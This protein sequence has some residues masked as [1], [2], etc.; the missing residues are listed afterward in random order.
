MPG[1]NSFGNGGYAEISQDKIKAAVTP[2]YGGGGSDFYSKNITAVT[3][4][5]SGAN[6]CAIFFY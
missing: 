1:G 6:G 2:T 5:Q 3:S 4:S